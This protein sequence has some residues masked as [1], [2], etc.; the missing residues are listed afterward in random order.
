M[1]YETLVFLRN[2]IGQFTIRVGEPDFRATAQSL[3]IALNELDNEIAVTENGAVD[4][5]LTGGG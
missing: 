2:I 5:Q 1:T 4:R 3:I